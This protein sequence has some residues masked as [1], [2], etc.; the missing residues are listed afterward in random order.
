MKDGV[1]G[2]GAD[3]QT[4]KDRQDDIVGGFMSLSE[5]N[6]KRTRQGAEAA[7]QIGKSTISIDW[8]KN[9]HGVY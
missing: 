8:R 9:K 2:Q 1:T 7:Y 6:S 3:G 5:R 4:H